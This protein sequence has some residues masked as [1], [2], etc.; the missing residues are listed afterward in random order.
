MQVK[1]Y[2]LK[3]ERYTVKHSVN[4]LSHPYALL[5]DL[6]KSLVD[7]ECIRLRRYWYHQGAVN[8]YMATRHG[9]LWQVCFQQYSLKQHSVN[10]LFTQKVLKS[11]IYLN[12]AK[13]KRMFW[14]FLHIE[15]SCLASTNLSL[16]F[17]NPSFT[18]LYFY[19]KTL[20]FLM[21]FFIC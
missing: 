3:K 4:F 2:H 17:L 14:K 13:Q 1:L 12:F 19:V 5:L 10:K 16:F 9:T 21:S 11:N 15:Q 6:D 7:M 8:R 18:I 20:S